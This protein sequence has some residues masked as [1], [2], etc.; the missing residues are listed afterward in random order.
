MPFSG[1]PRLAARDDV[2]Y[3]FN[4]ALAKEPLMPRCLVCVL[5]IPVAVC[6]QPANTH[7][8]DWRGPSGQGYADDASVPLKWSEQENVLWKTKLSGRGVSSPIVW[9]DRV[10]L[11]ASSANGNE[12]LVMCVSAK[13][14]KIL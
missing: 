10:F 12:R 13:D 2:P 4:F 5:L 9:G 14:G 11:T 3:H 6:A 7:W 1:Q 8:S